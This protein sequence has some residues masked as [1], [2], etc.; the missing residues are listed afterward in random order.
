M[1]LWRISDLTAAVHNITGHN[2]VITSCDFRIHGLDSYGTHCQI[3]SISRDNEFRLT[4]ISPKILQV[5]QIFTLN[6]R[7]THFKLL[8]SRADMPPL[9]LPLRRLATA[10]N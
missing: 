4:H 5:C 1:N 7:S 8:S 6:L 2:D 9:T 10:L 3:A